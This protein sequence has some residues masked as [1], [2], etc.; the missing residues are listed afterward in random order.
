MV[1]IRHI[2]YENYL[3]SVTMHDISILYCAV[4]QNESE[5][6]SNAHH[7]H[8]FQYFLCFWN[9][10]MMRPRITQFSLY[11]KTAITIQILHCAMLY[12][13]S[14]HYSATLHRTLNSHFHS[15]SCIDCAH[16]VRLLRCCIVFYIYTF[17]FFFFFSTNF[18]LLFSI[19]SKKNKNENEKNSLS[20]TVL[21]N[22]IKVQRKEISEFSTKEKKNSKSQR[23]G[24]IPV[25]TD[26]LKGTAPLITN[27][28]GSEVVFDVRERERGQVIGIRFFFAAFCLLSMEF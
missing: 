9:R 6:T 5:K 17:F 4:P 28:L 27:Q 8:K 7:V 20:F 16:I 23:N 21:K 26:G 24:N 19:P 15:N 2:K 22:N 18:F 14:I 3:L 13:Q 1:R 10:N 25:Q 12:S 11:T